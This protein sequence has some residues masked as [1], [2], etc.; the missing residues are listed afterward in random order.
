MVDGCESISKKSR[1]WDTKSKEWEGFCWLI[2]VSEPAGLTTQ[3]YFL[4]PYFLTI[5]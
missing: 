3:V 4:S 1:Y 2:Q 5:R